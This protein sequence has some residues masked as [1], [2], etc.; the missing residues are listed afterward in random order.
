MAA[1]GTVVEVGVGDRR[2]VSGSVLV[3]L[4]QQSLPPRITTAT[5]IHIT[6]TLTIPP[7]TIPTQIIPIHIRT[8]ILLLRTGMAVTAVVISS[9]KSTILGKGVSLEY[10]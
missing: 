6:P 7:T 4:V 1:T 3:S 5:I 2:S 10:P 8:V 9:R